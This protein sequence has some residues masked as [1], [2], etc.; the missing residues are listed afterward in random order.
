M[1]EV[2]MSLEN[3]VQGW[4]GWLSERYLRRSQLDVFPHGGGAAAI[5]EIGQ[6]LRLSWTKKF[7]GR[8]SAARKDGP[9]WIG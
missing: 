9:G 2:W 7:W 6:S 5:Q 3:V 8:E 1:K 4:S